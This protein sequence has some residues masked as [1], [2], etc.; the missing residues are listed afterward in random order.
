MLLLF[1]S[2]AILHS[3]PTYTEKV[4]IY[5]LRLFGQNGEINARKFQTEAL[6]LQPYFKVK[7]TTRSHEHFEALQ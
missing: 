4:R 6:V 7:L 2:S 3:M 1:Q 5:L